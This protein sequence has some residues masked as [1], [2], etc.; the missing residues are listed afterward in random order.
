MINHANGCV[1][2][3]STER[4]WN[5]LGLIGSAHAPRLPAR[6]RAGRLERSTQ[7]GRRIVETQTRNRFRST[8]PA[9]VVS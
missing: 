7:R 9:H 5:R 1:E 4:L 3:A 8:E 2:F 6:M